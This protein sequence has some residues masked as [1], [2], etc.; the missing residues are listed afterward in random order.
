VLLLET[1]ETKKSEIG[2][3]RENRNALMQVEV[4]GGQ[5]GAETMVNTPMQE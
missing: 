1:T 4:N 5:H 2:K 3:P